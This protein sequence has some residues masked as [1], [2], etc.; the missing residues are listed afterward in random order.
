MST[1]PFVQSITLLFCF[2][3]KILDY[4]ARLECMCFGR[5]HGSIDSKSS[6]AS[7]HDEMLRVCTLYS[8]WR[9]WFGCVR[10]SVSSTCSKRVWVRVYEWK[11][12]SPVWMRDGA[13]IC[14]FVCEHVWINGRH[15]NEQKRQ[16]A[17]YIYGVSM[18][19]GRWM[20]LCIACVHVWVRIAMYWNCYQLSFVCRSPW[21]WL[22][23]QNPTPMKAS[24]KVWI[25]WIF[26]FSLAICRCIQE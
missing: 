19:L 5:C 7:I 20:C 3:L 23:K 25:F 6:F 2:C 21:S 13:C 22:P 17:V 10:A 18:L 9:Y 14:V 26:Y 12:E 15:R 4:C 24:S 8:V 1:R 11:K 16:S